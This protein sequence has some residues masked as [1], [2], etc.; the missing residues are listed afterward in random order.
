MLHMIAS[1]LILDAA[2]IIMAEAEV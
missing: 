2:E 1:Q